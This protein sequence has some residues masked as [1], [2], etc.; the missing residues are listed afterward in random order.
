MDMKTVAP[1]RASWTSDDVRRDQSWTVRLEPQETADLFATMRR[2]YVPGKALVDYRQ[3]DFPLTRSLDTLNAAFAEV[4]NGRGLA[5]VKGLPRDGISP[6]EFAL[7]TWVIGLHFGVARPQNKVSAY[8]NEVKNTG[9]V[10]RS[11]TGRGYSSNAELDFHVDGADVVLLSCYN[12][13]PVG[14]TSMCSSSVKA[15]EVMMSERPDLV[16]VL[17][18]GVPFSRNGEEAP[19]EPAWHVQPVF[20][21]EGGRVFCM[22]VRNRVENAQKLPGAPELSARQ[23]EALDYLDEVVRRPGLMYSMQLEPGD[24]QLLSNHTAL[25]SR[26]EFADTPEPEKMRTLYRLWLATPDSP[27]LPAGWETFYGTR[28]PGAVRGGIRGQRYDDACRAFDAAQARAMGMNRG[29]I[30]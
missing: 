2:A 28:E 20:G 25:H 27:R 5:L 17:R 7:V 24:V 14:G 18:I 29:A 8:L 30:A 12:Q 26:T 15:Y 22:W 11:A 21:I 19:G 6:E 16:D 23:R 13:A 10:Y 4:R 1:T 3:H 9:T